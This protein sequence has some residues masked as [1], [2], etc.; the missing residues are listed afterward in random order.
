MQAV[1]LKLGEAY[2]TTVRGRAMKTAI[3]PVHIYYDVVEGGEDGRRYSVCTDV[4]RI[5]DC[6]SR[7]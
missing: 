1:E 6:Q 7:R 2:V 4:L 5:A 3:G